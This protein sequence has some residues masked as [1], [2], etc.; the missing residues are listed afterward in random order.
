MAIKTIRTCIFH[1]IFMYYM[2]QFVMKLNMLDL[3]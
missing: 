2:L 3:N 1:I